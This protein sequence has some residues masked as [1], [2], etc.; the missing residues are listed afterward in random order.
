V[1]GVCGIAGFVERETAGGRDPAG[2]AAAVA[3]MCRTIRHRGPDDEGIYVGEGL[4]MGMRRLSIIDLATGHQPIA[5]EDGT[6]Q[7]VFNGEIYNY[8]ALRADL[9]GRGH[10]FRT[11]SDTETIVHGYEE[12]GDAVFSR[13]RG[14][15]AIALWD[16]PRR[17]LVLARDPAG[18]K[19]LYFAE[20][21]GRLIFGSEIKALLASGQI[22]PA[23][24]LRALD[25]YLTFLYTPRDTSIFQNV[26]KLPP[27]HLLRWTPDGVT[28]AAYWT[29][30]AETR[31]TGSE[32]DAAEELHRALA[33]AVRSHMVSDVPV[34]AFLSGGLDSGVVVGLMAQASSQ[35]V[36]TFSIG[37]DDPAFD[38][39]DGARAIA[40]HFGTEHHEFVVR[41][42]AM[43]ILDRLI[44]HFDEPFGDASA[45]PTWYVSEMASRYVTVALSGDGG[46]E[47]FGGYDRYLPHPRVEAFDRWLG[48]TGRRLAGAA[49]RAV[50]RSRRGRNFLRHVSKDAPGRYADA[51][52]FFRADE[53]AALLTADVRAALPGIDAE[54][55]LLQR[56]DR[57]A[58]LDWR[59]QMM[60]VDFETYLPED[61][62]TKVDRMS[63]AHSLESRVPLLD[64]DVITL[65]SAFPAEMNIRGRERKRV[66]RRVAGRVLPPSA[67]A[68]RKQGFAVP[69]GAWFRGELRDLC[70]D[71]LQ[72]SRAR[73]RG[74]FNPGFVDRLIDDHLS[75]QRAHNLRLWQLLVFELWHRHYL[76]RAPAADRPLPS[77]AVRFRTEAPAVP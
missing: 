50:P 41:P 22:E 58:T 14:M 18:I 44:T 12:W 2:L 42:D 37:F 7:V 11:G 60:R 74:Y 48:P 28:Q 20:S 27:G 6:L 53:R 77:S 31:F 15:F 9:E 38:E 62:L 67:L 49:W 34:G 25:H 68:R 73:Q 64:V 30:P 3:G 65:A 19:P 4:A 57:F 32:E 61:V 52:A 47:L 21:R 1:N 23:L 46:D 40:S 66:F 56:F 43:S 72:S 76:D 63:M 33:A 71:V 24:D 26:R 36:R 17:H 10:R 75:G 55:S 5:N 29:L 54:T 59:S 51:V 45:I 8:A 13:L 16:A 69:V 70:S 39:L 35:P